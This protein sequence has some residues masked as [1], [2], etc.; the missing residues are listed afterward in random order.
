MDEIGIK[1]I[2][3]YVKPALLAIKN[4]GAYAPLLSILN[5]LSEEGM[6]SSVL[7]THNELSRVLSQITIAQHSY[8][9][10]YTMLQ[11]FQ[12]SASWEPQLRSTT[13]Q[14]LISGLGHD[15]GKIPR[16]SSPCHGR[17]RYD[18]A[19]VSANVVAD[20]FCNHNSSPPWLA[21]VLQAIRIHHSDYEVKNNYLQKLLRRADWEARMI[22]A[23]RIKGTII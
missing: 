19:I 16:Y 9:V 15:L 2:E 1:L 14:I 3:E 20:V 21:M 11:R 7:G 6:C 13:P 8:F 23:R 12:Q 18:H 22:E 17:G 5:I 4:S 10:A